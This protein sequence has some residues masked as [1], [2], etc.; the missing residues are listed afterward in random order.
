VALG[1]IS[2]GNLAKYTPIVLQLIRENPEKQF[3][4]LTSLLE[5]VSHHA[6]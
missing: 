6:V 2:F 1:D 3:R 5:L 4:P